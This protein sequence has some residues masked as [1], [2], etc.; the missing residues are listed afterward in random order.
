ML[1]LINIL[2]LLILTFGCTSS[3]IRENHY[4]S[5]YNLQIISPQDKYNVLLKY[6]LNKINVSSE[7][8]K[9]MYRL[10]ADVEFISEDA[11]SLNGLKPINVMN[12]TLKYKLIDD[13]ED[14][15]S[16][17]TLS[18]KINYGNVTSL[19]TKDQNTENVKERII[20]RLSVQLLNRIKLI[21]NK[22]EN[23]S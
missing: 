12:G 2:F 21:V 17:G 10:I 6:Q 3:D 9:K 1:Q 16:K 5:N 20:N 15:I 14:I 18:S 11:L 13:N 4:F 23:I 19:Y 7:K 22:I 8:E